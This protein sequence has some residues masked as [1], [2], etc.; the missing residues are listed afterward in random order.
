VAAA[1]V[2]A[3]TI[4]DVAQVCNVFVASGMANLFVYK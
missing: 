3:R 1:P 4:R 2:E